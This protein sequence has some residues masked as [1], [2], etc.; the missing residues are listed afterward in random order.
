M[1]FNLSAKE[2]SIDK[3]KINLTKSEYQICEFLARNKGQVFPKNKFMNRF[4]AMTE[5]A[6]AQL[7]QN[8]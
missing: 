3:E 4:M 2:I 6:I 8:M 5:K 1:K 7:L